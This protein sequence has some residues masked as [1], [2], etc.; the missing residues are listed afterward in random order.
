MLDIGVLVYIGILYQKEHPPE[1]WHNSSWD[2]LFAVLM[3]NGEYEMKV[4]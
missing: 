1:G 4:G 2:T 3:E